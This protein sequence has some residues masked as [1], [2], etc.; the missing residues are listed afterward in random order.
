MKITKEHIDVFQGVCL[1]ETGESVTKKKAIN[2]VGQIIAGALVSALPG[3]K[4][5]LNELLIHDTNGMF[6]QLVE[7]YFHSYTQ[8]K[9]SVRSQANN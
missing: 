2:I 7:Y 5:G 9:H 8:W 4:N 3:K 1:K 6:T